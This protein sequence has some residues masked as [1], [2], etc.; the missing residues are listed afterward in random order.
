M[1]SRKPVR[2]LLLSCG[3]FKG[4]QLFLLSAKRMAVSIAANIEYVSYVTRVISKQLDNFIIHSSII[5][6]TSQQQSFYW[7][8]GIRGGRIEND[9]SSA[10]SL[11]RLSV[12]IR[13]E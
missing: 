4:V 11:C 6:E 9:S 7:I 8:E 2:Y 10:D 5:N 1:F 13:F 12:V 3:Q